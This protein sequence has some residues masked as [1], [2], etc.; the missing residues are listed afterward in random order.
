[1]TA[2]KSSEFSIK[3]DEKSGTTD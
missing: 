3:S 1:V 2:E